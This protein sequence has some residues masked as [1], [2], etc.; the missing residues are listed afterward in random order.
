MGKR[1]DKTLSACCHAPIRSS[2]PAPDF[3]GDDPKTMQVGT[4]YCICTK[5]NNPCNFYI[6]IRKTWAIN[7]KTKINGD[8]RERITEHLTKKEIEEIRKNEDF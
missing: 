8:K 1:K 7:P 2:E 5:C 3:I 4:C 6:P